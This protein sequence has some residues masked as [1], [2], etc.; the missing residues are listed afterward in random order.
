[1]RKLVILFAALISPAVQARSP[2]PNPPS[3]AT[4]QIHAPAGA[5]VTTIIPDSTTPNNFEVV[6]DGDI[7]RWNIKLPSPAFDG[8]IITIGCPGGNVATLD[9][10]A[11]A[12]DTV[13]APPISSCAAKANQV[14]TYRLNAGVWAISCTTS[15]DPTNIRVYGFCPANIG[16]DNDAAWIDARNAVVD[17]ITGAGARSLFIPDGT[18]SISSPMTLPKVGGITLTGESKTGVTIQASA[19]MPTTAAM[20]QTYGGTTDNNFGTTIKNITFDGALRANSAIKL[21]T[22]KQ[23]TLDNLIINRI[24]NDGT[25]IIIGLSSVV[26]LGSYGHVI[27]NIMME[28]DPTKY[29]CSP[30]LI[31]KYGIYADTTATDN[32]IY[33]ITI[34]NVKTA[35]LHA[36][37]AFGQASMVHVYGYPCPNTSDDFRP[38]Y[39]FYSAGGYFRGNQLYGDGTK[40]ACFR[41]TG[42]E[43]LITGSQCTT[44]VLNNTSNGNGFDLDNVNKTIILGNII[45]ARLSSGGGT[46]INIIGSLDEGSTIAENSVQN[47]ANTMTRD[48]SLA[49]TPSSLATSISLHMA[50]IPKKYGSIIFESDNAP[51]VAIR[52]NK[53]EDGLG[54][55]NLQ[56]ITYSG[57]TPRTLIPLEI[58]RANNRAVFGK[59]AML[60]PVALATLG[61]CNYVGA[62][63]SIS[64]GTAALAWGATATG[65]GSTFYQVVC[66]G[67][68]WTVTGK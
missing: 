9:I 47:I 29:N 65:G 67:A 4:G 2:A 20:I 10:T 57:E 61:T 25:G 43:N 22:G 13:R 42:P 12:P 18:Y 16:A 11:T 23:F 56:F 19:V 51:Q 39:S 37:G 49:M 62:I 63:A 32:F 14:I 8:Q 17:P 46:P 68:H 15:T 21:S 66:N 31:P 53:E 36:A 7:A 50:S 24:A 40:L 59:P 34:K 30:T 28:F 54:N 41:V 45:D 64:D 26:G 52:K 6:A 48:L 5:T 3:P 1:M 58:D 38:D 60:T 35:G 33:A 27:T 55:Q 44:P